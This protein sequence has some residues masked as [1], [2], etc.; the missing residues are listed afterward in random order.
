MFRRVGNLV[1][2][3]IIKP[4][5]RKNRQKVFCI[6][7]N[8]TGTTSLKRSLKDLGYEVGNQLNA[9]RLL[10]DYRK[11][12]FD[13]IIKY[14]KTAEV[15]QD[16]PFSLPGTYKKVDKEFP[17]SKFILTIR[18]S[19]EQWFQSLANFHSKLF[20]KGKIP[21]IENLKESEYVYTGY[22]F[23]VLTSL[24]SKLKSDPYNK[25]IL[26]DCYTIYNDEVITY[27]K[28]RTNDLLVINLS[29]PDSYSRLLKFLGITSETKE[30]PWENKT[31][32][33]KDKI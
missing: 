11:G 19:P 21:T 2:E 14:C 33:I 8:K 4:I 30:F 24:S 23:Q 25:K 16:V 17:N 31:A 7:M 1:R 3:N 12:D 27:F 22:I 15:F 20:G 9:E 6:G 26:T 32:N 5:K 18:D 28:N 10:I 13:S 29:E